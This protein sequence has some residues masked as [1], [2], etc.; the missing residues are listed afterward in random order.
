MYRRWCVQFPSGTPNFFLCSPL[1]TYHFM[2]YYSL[3]KEYLNDCAMQLIQSILPAWLTLKWSCKCN[4]HQSKQDSELSMP[5]SPHLCGQIQEQPYKALVRSI[6]EYSAT[7]WDPYVAKNNNRLK[8]FNPEQLAGYSCATT[9]KTVSLICYLLL[10]GDDLE[11]RWSDA[12]LC[13]LYK[14]CNG[15]AIYECD[16]LQRE[17]KSRMDIRLSSLCHWF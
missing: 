14:Q 13:M 2:I 1:H 17:H 5:Q 3:F 6:V 15:L 10:N 12:R 7:I 8:W 16:K 9:D 4:Y 11:L